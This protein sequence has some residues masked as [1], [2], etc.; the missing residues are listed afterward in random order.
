M[1]IKFYINNQKQLE[2]VTNFII[3][4]INKKYPLSIFYGKNEFI[5]PLFRVCEKQLRFLVKY[6]LG[7]IDLKKFYY[8]YHVAKCVFLEKEEYSLLDCL[9]ANKK[10]FGNSKQQY[11]K[12]N[13][14]SSKRFLK[15]I[16]NILNQTGEIC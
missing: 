6:D 9:K 7:Q 16:Q 15:I 12:L 11:K 10:K 8:K 5:L 4:K 14:L 2:E 13:S 1:E 3:R